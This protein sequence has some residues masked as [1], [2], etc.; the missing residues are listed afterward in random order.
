MGKLAMSENIVPFKPCKIGPS[1]TP[2]RPANASASRPVVNLP[3]VLRGAAAELQPATLAAELL[4]SGSNAAASPI[5]QARKAEFRSLTRS[6]SLSIAV[7]FRL[8]DEW[9]AEVRAA[10][11]A[12]KARRRAENAAMDQ[13]FRAMETS[14]IA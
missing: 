12:A 8:L 4:A 1:T 2:T 10:G 7:Q 11:I 14:D 5:W 6:R 13:F 3:L 9:K